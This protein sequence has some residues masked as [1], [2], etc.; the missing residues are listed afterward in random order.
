MGAGVRHALSGAA[1]RVPRERRGN[2]DG[3]TGEESVKKVVD[4][5][6]ISAWDKRVVGAKDCKEDG[7]L[8]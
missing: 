3:S 5:K 6:G 1:C 2:P 8:P 4:L 7:F